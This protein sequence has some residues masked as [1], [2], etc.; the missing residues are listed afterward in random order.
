M[1]Y[2]MF[3]A[4]IAVLTIGL[5]F[6]SM[7]TLA[8][9]G[10]RGAARSGSV[11][12][13]VQPSAGLP[14]AAHPLPEVTTAPSVT[15]APHMLRSD[16]MTE[17]LPTH[18]RRFGMP[19]G[20]HDHNRSRTWLHICCSLRVSVG[21]WL[22][23]R[24]FVRNSLRGNPRRLFGQLLRR[25][26]RQSKSPVAGRR[27]RLTAFRTPDQTNG[28]SRMARKSSE[29]DR[30][31]GMRL[32]RL[33]RPAHS[34]YRSACS[35]SILVA[36]RTLS[37]VWIAHLRGCRGRWPKVLID[38][39]RLSFMPS[40][41]SR[42]TLVHAHPYSKPPWRISAST[43]SRVERS[44]SRIAIETFSILLNGRKVGGSFTLEVV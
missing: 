4:G 11:R 40:Y 22:S 14:I 35:F 31:E 16:E 30:R 44:I 39:I 10:G 43:H 20:L 21:V 17:G 9:S 7:Q 15:P 37:S 36:C 26:Y 28:L 23:R 34:R 1:I 27:R 19:G 12:G 25:R 8:K 5:L 6:A 42:T 2:R 41:K 33:T 3:A 38:L 18:M 13:A 24:V 32:R 29:A